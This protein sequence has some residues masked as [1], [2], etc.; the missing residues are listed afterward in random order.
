MCY[1]P[2]FR[3]M[4][5]DGGWKFDGIR[6]LQEKGVDTYSFKQRYD[7]QVITC[8]SC[9]HCR[10][11][12]TLD[13][14]LRCMHELHTSDGVGC[15]ITLTYDDDNVPLDGSLQPPKTHLKV[16][17]N[18]L[19]RKIKR[20]YRYFQCGEYG[21]L[22][23]RPHYHALLFGYKPDDLELWKK[24]KSG[25]N[26]YTSPTLEKAWKKG[27]VFVG[28]ITRQSAAYTAAYCQKKITGKPE[29]ARYREKY[30]RYIM[31]EGTGE[32]LDRWLVLP[33]FH[34]QSNRPGIGFDYYFQYESDFFPLDECVFEGKKYPVPR[35]YTERLL[36]ESNPELFE[37]I[38]EKRQD[39]IEFEAT[40]KEVMDLARKEKAALAV[41]EF[42]QSIREEKI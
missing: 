7:A 42:Y 10:M 27:R 22:N 17:H 12:R 32:I 36:K 41:N 2:L 16:F 11:K 13:W 39:N 24:S 35:Y 31:E 23:N 14:S 28:N 19:K 18:A 6:K 40:Y 26:I 29:S 5:Y 30:T 20:S 8:G 34:T 25:H 9:F 15:F 37:E 3:Y 33:E 38:K 4:G 1:R 21:D